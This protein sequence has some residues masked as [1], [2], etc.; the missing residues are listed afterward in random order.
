MRARAFRIGPADHDKFLSVEA[1]GFAPVAAVA[2]RIG[3]VARLGDD[4]LEAHFAGMLA[5]KLAVA[6]H[7][8]V[9]LKA[10]RAFDERL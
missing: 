1:F 7:V 2:R 9:L 5:D 3:R 10:G 4:A 6:G 8:V